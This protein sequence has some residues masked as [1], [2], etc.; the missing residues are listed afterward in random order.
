MTRL[1]AKTLDSKTADVLCILRKGTADAIRLI[2]LPLA[3]A[4]LGTRP[5]EI[6]RLTGC[7]YAQAVRLWREV[8][9]VQPVP[10]ERRGRRKLRVAPRDMSDE[11]AHL[12]ATAF[13]HEYL[14]TY[15]YAQDAITGER[16]V[17][18][19]VITQARTH[20]LTT[21]GALLVPPSILVAIGEII[22]ATTHDLP[23]SLIAEHLFITCRRCDN[24]YLRLPLDQN[25]LTSGRSAV[26]CPV[27][28]GHL[29]LRK[30]AI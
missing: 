11:I 12:W 30:N 25:I 28:R 24:R 16:I 29:R 15:R 23:P 5:T 26:S 9:G 18:A 3:L 6:T 17:M 14:M 4:R 1:L 27:C 22:D 7:Q 2:I 21:R 10:P 19:T 8:H 13:A 20:G